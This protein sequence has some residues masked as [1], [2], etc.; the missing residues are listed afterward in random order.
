MFFETAGALLHDFAVLGA[1]ALW[2]VHGAFMAFLGLFQ[3]AFE[4]ISNLFV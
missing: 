1:L 4:G 3:V 2:P